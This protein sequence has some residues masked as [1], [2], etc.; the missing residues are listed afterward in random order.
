[1]LV[2]PIGFMMDEQKCFDFLVSILHGTGLHCDKCGN[3][4][5]NCGVH[6]RDRAPVLYYRCSCGRIFN[7]FA[8]T[9][10]QGTHRKCSALVLLL[11]GITQGKST[12]HLSKELGCDHWHL[13]ELRHKLQDNALLASPPEAL[14]ESVVECDE[15]YQNAGEKRRP[16]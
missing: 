12:L 8:G 2:F 4:V 14:Q 13:L 15:M 5:E 1:M 3:A 10:F 9:V 7:A 11:Q 16:A 6:R